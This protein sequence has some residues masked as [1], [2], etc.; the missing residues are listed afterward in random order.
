MVNSL[1]RLGLPPNCP[2]ENRALAVDL[3][4]LIVLWEQD[5]A[6]SFKSDNHHPSTNLR[7]VNT[8]KLGKS[9]LFDSVI[10][11]VNGI[12]RKA[13]REQLNNKSVSQYICPTCS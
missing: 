2:V 5:N 11:E 12:I 7:S 1:N 10:A 6:N 8:H 9:P 13:R 4:E 3:A